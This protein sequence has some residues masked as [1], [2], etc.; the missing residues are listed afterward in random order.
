MQ[1][2]KPKS[3]MESFEV[4]AHGFLRPNK[5]ESRQELK[6]EVSN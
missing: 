2:G 6:H 1:R 5:L 3:K 4:S